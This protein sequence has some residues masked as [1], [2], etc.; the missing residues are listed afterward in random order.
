M[1]IMNAKYIFAVAAVLFSSSAYIYDTTGRTENFWSIFTVLS[2]GC[3]FGTVC[4]L[5]STYYGNKV[6]GRF[7]KIKHK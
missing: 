7:L 6:L 1:M 2:L 4:F 3:F 5:A